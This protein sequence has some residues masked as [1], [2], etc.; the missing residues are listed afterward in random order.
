MRDHVS[1]A[2]PLPQPLGEP[3]LIAKEVAAHLRISV[4]EVYKLRREKRLPAVK[5]GSNYRW[6]PETVRAFVRELEVG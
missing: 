5:L 2:E 1:M 6:R 4:E 3:L